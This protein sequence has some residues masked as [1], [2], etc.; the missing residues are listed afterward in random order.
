MQNNSHL[1]K[2]ISSETFEA[3]LSAKD[4]KEKRKAVAVL[5]S[6]T[7]GITVELGVVSNILL[8]F[9][10]VGQEFPRKK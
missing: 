2:P 8:L 7:K 4:H 6:L 9:N 1:V 3:A 5:A 10:C